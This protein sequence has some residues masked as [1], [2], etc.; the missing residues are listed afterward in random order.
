VLCRDGYLAGDDSRRRAELERA[1]LDDDV[2]AIVAARGG[3]GAMR[4]LLDL[5]WQELVRRPKW[6]VGFSDFTALH[7]MAWR[8][9][10]ASVHGSN[11]AGLGMQASP[12]VR[13]AWLASLE[14]SAEERPRARVWGGLR[15]VHEGD[16]VGPLVGGNL[17][18]L[19]AMAAAGLLS[20]PSGAVL[21]L[22]DVGEAPY[23]VDRMLTS[24][25]L[26]G[27]LSRVAAIVLGGFE[28]CA[29]RADGRTVDEVIAERTRS[30]AV[31]VLA[32]APFG[33]G[34]PNEAFVL[35]GSATVRGDQVRLT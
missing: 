5:P 28:G 16:A 14:R 32:G 29:P 10:L 13:A 15:V 33:H 24:L 3:F 1:F 22:E 11:V 23:R 18:L 20:I 26:A 19:H 7:A 12:W 25:M 34:A 27:H 9:G 31:P 35:G 8:A 4:V 2:K 6:I 30:L 21:A 17:T